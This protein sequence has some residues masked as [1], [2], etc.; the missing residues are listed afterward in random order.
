MTFEYELRLDEFITATA[1]PAPSKIVTLLNASVVFGDDERY[2]P[3]PV[4][5]TKLLT[6]L[7][8]IVALVELYEAMPVRTTNGEVM[9]IPLPSEPLRVV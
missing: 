5:P 6:V 7:K 3:N 4:G 8:P 1:V 2:I 9:L